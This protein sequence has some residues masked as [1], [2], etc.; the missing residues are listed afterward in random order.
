MG[1]DTPDI[2]LVGVRIISIHAPAWGATGQSVEHLLLIKNF[3]PRSRMGSDPDTGARSAWLWYFNPRSRMGSDG[4]VTFGVDV[5]R[6]DFNPR[7]RM[8][9]DGG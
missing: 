3:N 8:G 9:S 6:Y 7:S 5:A 4:P 2:V 1:S